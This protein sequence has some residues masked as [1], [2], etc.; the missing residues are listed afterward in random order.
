[1][2]RTL[3]P[4]VTS[5]LVLSLSACSVRGA[6]TRILVPEGTYSVRGLVCSAPEDVRGETDALLGLQ[7]QLAEL[8][9]TCADPSWRVFISVGRT[10]EMKK[11][12]KLN[13]RH[14]V[15]LIGRLDGSDGHTLIATQ[16]N[17]KN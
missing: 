8:D 1:M 6:L 15:F 16:L 14:E 4:L 3:L 5:L 10:S 12:R 2:W 7:F 17:I 11:A 13:I 9:D